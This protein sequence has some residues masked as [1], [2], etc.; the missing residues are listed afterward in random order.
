M[1]Y[2]SLLLGCFLE[3]GTELVERLADFAFALGGQLFGMG[4]ESRKR[5]DA[6]EGDVPVR[7]VHVFQRAFVQRMYE[8]CRTVEVYEFQVLLAG[9]LHERGQFLDFGGGV[10]LEDE[11]YGPG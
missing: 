11:V 8:F 10:V 7:Y 1:L 2:G 5:L 9:P 4:R 6:A 3:I